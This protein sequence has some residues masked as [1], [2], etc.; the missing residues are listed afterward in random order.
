[1]IDGKICSALSKTSSAKCY[2]CEATPT[3]MNNLNVCLRK[4]GHG[5]RYEFGL[6]PLHAYIRFFEYLLHISYRLDQEIWQ[7]R[8]EEAKRKFL[9]RKK[10]I[11]SE[12]RAKMGLMKNKNVLFPDLSG[13][14]FND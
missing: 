9:I 5:D 13:Q 14:Y 12:F 4:D 2:I 6:S 11:Q 7:I 1:M 8:S 10:F 3:Q